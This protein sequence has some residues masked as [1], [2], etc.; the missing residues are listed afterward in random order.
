MR[1]VIVQRKMVIRVVGMNDNRSV[2]GWQDNIF[3]SVQD[4]CGKNEKELFGSLDQEQK[5]RL[6]QALNDHSESSD[7]DF[8]YNTD[9]KYSA[10]YCMKLHALTCRFEQEVLLPPW[11]SGLEGQRS[12]AT[13]VP[14]FLKTVKLAAATCR[15][16]CSSCRRN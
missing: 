16:V 9:R 5:A 4:S 14:R 15:P 8:L 11:W 7:L 12:L 6:N 2:S 3:Q 10:P 13:R 1:M